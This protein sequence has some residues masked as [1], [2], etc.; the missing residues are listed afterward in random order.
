MNDYLF[1]NPFFH[2]VVERAARLLLA[3]MSRQ[4]G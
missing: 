2:P 1:V 3:T 4:P